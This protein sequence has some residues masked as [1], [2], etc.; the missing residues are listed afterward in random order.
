MISNLSSFRRNSKCN[1]QV[2]YLNELVKY[3][4]NK[5]DSEESRL[6]AECKIERERL[7]CNKNNVI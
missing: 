1:A 5:R 4:R 7:N 3:L 6:M 2:E